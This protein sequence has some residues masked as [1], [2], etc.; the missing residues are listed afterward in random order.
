MKEYFTLNHQVVFYV[1]STE[2]SNKISKNEFVKLTSVIAELFTQLFGGA[3]IETVKGFYKAQNGE[4]IIE[5]INRVVSFTD[6]KT[7]E[8]NLD[9]V[10]KT[11]A[12]NK[13]N[14]QQESILIEID[15]VAKFID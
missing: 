10:I 5:T 14:W 3:T 13:T 11:A 9:D 8:A 6:D 15:R 1:P 7:L 4:Y 12:I 2:Y